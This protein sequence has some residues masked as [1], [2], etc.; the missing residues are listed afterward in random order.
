MKVGIS[1]RGFT[2]VELLIVIVIIAILAAI[3]VVA[4]NGIQQRARSGQVVSGMTQYVKAIMTYTTD[5]GV[6]PIANGFIACFGGVNDCH[7]AANAAQT[8]ALASE[9]SPYTNGASN[10]LLKSSGSLMNYVTNYVMPDGSSYTGMYIYF[11]QYGTS[12]CPTLGG[13]RFMYSSASGADLVC[14]YA[15]PL[16]S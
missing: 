12:T 13:V 15:L 2:I 4:Y 16:S 6:Y 11:L 9:L 14:R 1:Q 3:T 7:G 10:S 8:A 5:K